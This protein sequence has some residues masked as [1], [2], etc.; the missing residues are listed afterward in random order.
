MLINEA[1]LA[2]APMDEEK[3]RSSLD[4]TTVNEN[5]T[6]MTL[7]A[8]S[9]VVSMTTCSAMEE[10]MLIYIAA[11][12]V[13]AFSTTATV[14]MTV[15]TTATPVMTMTEMKEEKDEEGKVKEFPFSKKIGGCFRK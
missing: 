4:A 2:V 9:M 12:E 13:A 15:E 14:S 8:A 3:C 5:G 7:V 10:R 6:T 1:T 11:S